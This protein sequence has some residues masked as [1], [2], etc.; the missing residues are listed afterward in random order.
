MFHYVSQDAQRLFDRAQRHIDPLR[1][2]P[3]VV[4][5]ELEL[6]LVTPDQSNLVQMHRWSLVESCDS[7]AKVV[8]L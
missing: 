3:W 4:T 6:H 7:V 1:L 2:N 5:G 8:K